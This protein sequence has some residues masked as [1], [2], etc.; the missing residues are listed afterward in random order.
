M[1]PSSFVE[2]KRATGLRN[3]RFRLG[4]AVVLLGGLLYGMFRL[5]QSRRRGEID[6]TKRPRFSQKL[7]A[8][9]LPIAGIDPA[10]GGAVPPQIGV[11]PAE[12]GEQ[13]A[14]MT[15]P[16]TLDEVFDKGDEIE[17]GPFFYMLY[18]VFR[19]TPEQLAAEAQETG[20]VAWTDLWEK[21]KDYRGKA[22]TVS[23]RV[24]KI[25]TQPLGKSP[26]GL[27]QAAAYRIRS[28]EAQAQGR[29]ELYDVYALKKLYGALLYDQVTVTGRFLKAQ[30]VAP[31]GGRLD[32]PDLHVGVV[33]A[34]E[35]E[36]LT[37]LKDPDPPGP[38][39]DCN[40]PEARPFY[41]YLNRAGEASVE[42]IRAVDPTP[43]TYM[44][45]T[46]QADRYRGTKVALR[47]EL[48]SLTRR[49]LPENPLGLKEVFFG[50]ILGGYAEDPDRRDRKMNSFYCHSVAPGG[51][52]LG[53]PVVVYGY[54]FKIWSYPSKGRE[55]VDSPVIV[56]QYMA[57]M[58]FEDDYTFEI[59]LVVLAGVTLSVLLVAFHRER[60]RRARVAEARRRRE[61]AR[62][63]QN[64]NEAA[65]RLAH[66]GDPAPPSEP[67]DAPE[68][69]DE[70]P[71]DGG[72]TDDGSD[73]PNA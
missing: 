65:R 71:D 36:P 19:D 11:D 37:Y 18:R 52:R 9:R 2:E 45:L 4:L 47:G 53:D 7:T 26:M 72:G 17:P 12:V 67:D 25:W 1:D 58:E 33:V 27:E 49:Q 42:E 44:D 40:R 3:A 57:K 46:L 21:A 8:E 43:P 31:E 20:Q 22:L 14:F 30:T 28:E 62:L 35:F 29:T 73:E 51:V 41:W 68:P 55:L 16:K 6:E 59:M 10:A 39:V 5:S 15:D 13:F 24:V 63:P 66:A 32:D 64:L 69:G 60:A 56:G 54:F 50:Q 34:R 23:G 61:L 70:P 38:I 48:A